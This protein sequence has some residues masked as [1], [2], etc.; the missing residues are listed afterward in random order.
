[1][2]AYAESP[3]IDGDTLVCTPGGAE[4][5]M[6]AVD[7]KTGDIIWKSHI[8]DAG[9]AAYASAIA[10]EVGGTRQYIQYMR[11]GVVSVAAKDGASLWRYTKLATP[12]NCCTPIVRGDHVFVSMAGPGG[13]GHA[14]LKLSADGREMAVVYEGKDLAVHH[15]GVVL[16]GDSLYGATNSVL[17]CLDFKTGA[18]K[19]DNRSV[20][21]GSIAAAD[22][23]LYVRAE[24]GPIALVEATP[25]GYKEAGRFDQPD[26]SGKN[27]W[28]HPVISGGRLY[29]RDWDLL[30]CYDIKAR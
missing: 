21:K 30:L 7:K 25:A 17:A 5:S 18:K 23:R 15:G 16:V 27:A 11:N 2:W 22:G 14:L 29:V 1:M 20:G 3:L 4:T 26:R 24:K 13:S 9:E 6:A 10:A 19:W 12:T 28:P 8:P